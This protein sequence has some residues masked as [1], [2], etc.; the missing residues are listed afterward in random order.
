[1]PDAL[2]IE[3][4]ARRLSTTPADIRARL[5]DGRLTAVEVD[6]ETRVDFASVIAALADDLSS[7]LDALSGAVAKEPPASRAQAAGS[8]AAAV[9]IP[10][11]LVLWALFAGVEVL[12]L[13][14][15][16]ASAPLP[17]W[18]FVLGTAALLG[19]LAAWARADGQLG[20]T[21][22]IGVALYGR[23]ATDRGTVG[24]TWLVLFMV[25]LVPLRSYVV[26]DAQ[27][28]ARPMIRT[29]RYRLSPHDGLCWPQVLPVVVG[30]WT[31]LAGAAAWVI[32][33]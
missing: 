16:P 6:G 14:D 10:V 19:G 11:A 18:A 30:V 27:T 21:N 1:M 4:A 33:G 7:S 8:I 26:H 24:T 29:T 13:G 22:G 32:Y 17:G 23:R 3:D 12:A 15:D 9:V 20:T 2:S 5:A 31:A 25:P 28:D